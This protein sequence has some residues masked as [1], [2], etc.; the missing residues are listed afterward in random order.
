M[1]FSF[2]H[3]PSFPALSVLRGCDSKAVEAKERRK[4]KEREREGQ[5]SGG[6]GKEKLVQNISTSKHKKSSSDKIARTVGMSAP[7]FAKVKAVAEAAEEEPEKYQVVAVP[8]SGVEK[9]PAAS[10]SLGRSIIALSP[11]CLR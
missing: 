5:K 10:W 1:G 2:F 9:D 3:H 4:A 11:L 7:T 8:G 6:S